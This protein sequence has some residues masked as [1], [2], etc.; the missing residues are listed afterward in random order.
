MTVSG[1]PGSAKEG[2]K[3]IRR[4]GWK[5]ELSRFGRGKDFTQPAFSFLA[6]PLDL[7]RLSFKAL[8]ASIC[9]NSV[10]CASRLKAL[11]M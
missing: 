9:S 1:V 6:Y 10:R 7:S 2:R 5:C 4:Q 8:D 11:A 3:L